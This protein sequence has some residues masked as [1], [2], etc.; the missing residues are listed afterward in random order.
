MRLDEALSRIADIHQHLD[1]SEVYDGYRALPVAL[2][3]VLAVL[4][5]LLQPHVVPADETL[6]YIIFWVMVALLSGV[7]CGSGIVGRYWRDTEYRRRRAR[8]ALGQFAPCV[9]AGVLA[10][11]ACAQV[12]AA[13]ALLPG[14]WALLFSLG[15]FASRPYLPRAAGWIG[16]YYLTAA[17]WLLSLAASG[18]SL[19]P[20]AM[21]MTFGV[22]QLAA[23]LMLYW[24]IERNHG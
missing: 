13:A 7:I 20:W 18:A 21:G 10:T 24:N 14:L 8:R 17:G 15:I 12:P 9:L 23:A 22:G 1:R 6:G 19:N 5:A 3:G 11:L 16:V 2:S 4:A